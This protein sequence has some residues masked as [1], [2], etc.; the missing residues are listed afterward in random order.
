MFELTVAKLNSLLAFVAK[1][2]RHITNLGPLAWLVF[3]VLTAMH[4]RVG[5]TD[6]M[7]GTDNWRVWLVEVLGRGATDIGPRVVV[8]IG[9]YQVLGSCLGSSCRPQP[10]KGRSYR[11]PR[12]WN[13]HTKLET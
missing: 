11:I 4:G 5:D 7:R 8:V 13:S 1:L 10:I 9:S 12:R 2:E 3:S 6:Y